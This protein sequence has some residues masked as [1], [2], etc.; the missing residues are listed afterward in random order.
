MSDLQYVR[1][2]VFKNGEKRNGKALIVPRTWDAFLEAVQK[3]LNLFSP[4]FV[5]TEEGGLIDTLDEIRR[6]DILYASV[7]NKFILPDI[8]QI[9]KRKVINKPSD[10]LEINTES[11]KIIE[12]EKKPE[13]KIYT[14]YIQVAPEVPIITTVEQ[15]ADEPKSIFSPLIANSAVL[16]S[17]QPPVFSSLPSIPN[18]SIVNPIEKPTPP[19]NK[20]P[21]PN[22][23]HLKKY[24]PTIL[25]LQHLFP[26]QLLADL[27][28]IAALCNG[29]LTRCLEMML[30]GGKP[31]DHIKP[32]EEIL[33]V[34]KNQKII[35]MPVN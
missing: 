27:T 4:P 19:S 13:E 14:S 31:K 6:D 33:L 26:Q 32:K 9:K 8:P 16:S 5:F 7:D 10:N 3:K 24:E 30:D 34:K 28:S 17:G 21:V 15:N 12:Q 23:E 1:V 18:T 2:N 25:Q 11:N 22:P 20:Q 35:N 29:N